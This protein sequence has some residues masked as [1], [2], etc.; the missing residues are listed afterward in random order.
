MGATFF[1]VA[2]SAHLTFEKVCVAGIPS[3][4]RAKVTVFRA[5]IFVADVAAMNMGFT[6]A[7]AADHAFTGAMFTEFLFAGITGS[8]AFTPDGSFAGRALVSAV[9]TDFLTGF[10]DCASHTLFA[11]PFAA[12]H[13]LE[14]ML[15]AGFF[16]TL[17]TFFNSA[18]GA[19]GHWTEFTFFQ[20]MTAGHFSAK[21][22]YRPAVGADMFLVLS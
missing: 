15:V 11:G 4:C 3:A 1:T 17:I 7:L 8:S 12:F 18:L 20:V 2:N 9:S 19:D 16:T 22:A 6:E 10:G 14:R 21:T 13:T 5:D